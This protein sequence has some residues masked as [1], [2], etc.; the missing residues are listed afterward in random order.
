MKKAKVSILPFQKNWCK[1]DSDKIVNSFNYHAIEFT[2]EGIK[3]WQYY[4]IGSGNF[5]LFSK[6]WFFQS[7]F[8]W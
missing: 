5:Q 7:G 3:L 1:V 2:R 8:K 6:N 4:R